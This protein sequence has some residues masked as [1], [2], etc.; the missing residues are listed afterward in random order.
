[1]KM[2]IIIAASMLMGMFIGT[3]FT[4]IYMVKENIGLEKQLDNF[5]NLY[6]EHKRRS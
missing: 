5:R 3:I 2:L 6:Y 1:M 4:F